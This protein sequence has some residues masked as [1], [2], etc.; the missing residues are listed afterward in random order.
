MPLEC[1][2]PGADGERCAGVIT[3]YPVPTAGSNLNGITAGQDGTLWFAEAAAD[4]FSHG[5][6]ALVALLA[7]R[8]LFRV[9]SHAPSVHC[10]NR[11]VLNQSMRR[12]E[13]KRL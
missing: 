12:R 5:L 8:R 3:E 11:A 2:A 7:E 13:G 10:A 1:F 9:D 6:A 4:V